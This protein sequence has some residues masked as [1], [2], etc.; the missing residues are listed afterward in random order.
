MLT[1]AKTSMTA[2]IAIVLALLAAAAPAARADI[3]SISAAGLIQ[4]NPCA[5][6]N[7]NAELDHGVMV[8]NADARYYAAIDFP[9]NGNKICSLSFAYQDINN[10]DPMTVRL[11][12]KSFAVGS[13]PFSN[14]TV[15]ASV[16]SATGV[17]QTVRKSTVKLSPQPSINDTNAAYFIE[18][19]APT[20]NLNI[21]GVQIDHRPSCP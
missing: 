20:I 18:V 11:L 4:Q 5:Q 16:S 8:A 12:R 7:C 6:S 3:I 2:A 17:V 1:S 19:E 9:V 21:L 14:P 10:N 13:D 15:V